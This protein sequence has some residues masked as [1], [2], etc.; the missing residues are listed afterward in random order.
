M[1]QLAHSPA[2][3]WRLRVAACLAAVVLGAGS[4]LP[5]AAQTTG[6]DNA[7]HCRETTR[8]TAT[9]SD[10]R[11]LRGAGNN[12]P[13]RATLRFHNRGSRPLVLTYVDGSASAVDDQGHRYQMQNSSRALRGLGVA[14][15]RAFDPR[16]T[17]APG[18]SA[19][20]T[21]EVS[22][23]IK[24][25]YGT[26]FDLSLSVRE[27]EPL[28]GQQARLGRETVLRYTGLS[29]GS[30]DRPGGSGGPADA[31][32]GTSAVAQPP[33]SPPTLSG[34]DTDTACHGQTPCVVNGPLAAHVQGLQVEA[35]RNNAQ[36]VI[37]TVAF[38]NISAAP[39]VLNYK[40]SSGTML[41]E[42]G[43]QY[44]VDWRYDDAVQGMPVST[45]SRASSQFTLAPGETRSAR[46]RY[47]RYIGK[48]PL[49][50]TFSPALAV[51]Q[52]ELLPSNQL[53]LVREYALDFGAVAGGGATDLRRALKGLGELFKR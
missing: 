50:S 31:G 26:R 52:Y 12:R 4:A 8:F 1:H 27:V 9:L 7:P 41:D 51:E 28:P 47:T 17:L 53:R 46:F 6:C 45:R 21:V 24:G 29:D 2:F 33:A 48:T 3:D 20:S 36:G 44:R 11:V 13:L 38:R 19:D 35:P 10:F 40:Q 49:G 23:F 30:G 22:A 32:G 34:A 16:F 15:R 5:A 42:H 39:M 25:I 37:V 18:E 43:Q 14:T